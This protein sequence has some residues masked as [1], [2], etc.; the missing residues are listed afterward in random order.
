MVEDQQE[1]TE[2]TTESNQRNVANLEP[3]STEIS[4]KG[5]TTASSFAAMMSAMMSDVLD[6]RVSPVTANAVT[7]AGGKLL[8]VVEMR[9]K[10]AANHGDVNRPADLLLISGSP[11]DE[12]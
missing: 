4:N 9:Y 5:V 12:E 7:N 3:R 8:K 1:A 2:G 11:E 6:G 10:Y